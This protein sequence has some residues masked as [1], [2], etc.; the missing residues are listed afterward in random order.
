MS[1][2][3]L[4]LVEIVLITFAACVAVLA[5]PYGKIGEK[6]AALGGPAGALGPAQGDETDAPFG[7]RY[8]HFKNGVIYWH[9]EIGEAFA[10]WGAI[11]TKWVQ[12]GRVAY[13][14]PITDE[15]ATPDGRGRYNHFRAI[16]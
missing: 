5:A 4:R 7:G 13:G 15:R 6:D 9:P 12:L 2:T 10:V 11:S 3:R 1:R 14:Y 8:H 16:H